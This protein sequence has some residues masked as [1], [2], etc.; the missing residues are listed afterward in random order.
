MLRVELA[1]CTWYA[2]M[3]LVAPDFSFAAR[4]T[5]P[6]RATLSFHH[7]RC[8]KKPFRGLSYPH[9]V[10]TLV[11]VTRRKPKSKIVLLNKGPNQFKIRLRGPA[12][13]W[14]QSTRGS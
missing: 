5:R 3:L 13:E 1:V 11:H 4:F 10:M 6:D 7:G 8:R 12:I 14:T 2:F 9:R